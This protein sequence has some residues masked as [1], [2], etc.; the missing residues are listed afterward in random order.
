MT[1]HPLASK[2][3]KW[4]DDCH[5]YALLHSSNNCTSMR[6]ITYK[7]KQYNIHNHFFWLS[8]QDAISL[9]TEKGATQLLQDAID[10]PIPHE[11]QSDPPDWCLQGDPYLS[12]VLPSLNLSPLAQ[13]L[14]SDLKQLHINSLHLR[15]SADPSLHLLSW[16]AGVYQLRKLLK[17]T[18]DWKKMWAKFKQLEQSLQFGVYEFGF[19]KR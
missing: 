14:L 17:D 18:E 4:V 8:R 1:D 9:Y 11:Y 16:D 10:H 3:N 7:G 6:D 5:I 12:H 13:D 15:S 19:L 2:Y